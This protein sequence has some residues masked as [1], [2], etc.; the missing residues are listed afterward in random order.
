M[1]APEKGEFRSQ[2]GA[3][4]SYGKIYVFITSFCHNPG[5]DAPFPKMFIEEEAI[6]GPLTRNRAKPWDIDGVI[7]P[8]RAGKRKTGPQN[9][10]HIFTLNKGNTVH[11]FVSKGRI[12]P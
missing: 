12:W 6:S 5:K 10:F 11:V 7:F 2:T 3:P 9:R 8:L 4:V 1:K